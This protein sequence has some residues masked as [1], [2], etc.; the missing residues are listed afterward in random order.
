MLGLS[1]TET[2]RMVRLVVA[3]YGRLEAR[4]VGRRPDELERP[5]RGDTG[6]TAVAILAAAMDDAAAIAAAIRA[7][8]PVG[9]A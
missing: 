6:S 1:A 2:A 3:T 5:L 7:G 8:T 9:G 4:F